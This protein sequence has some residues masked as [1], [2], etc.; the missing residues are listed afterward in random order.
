MD[1]IVLKIS[2][3]FRYFTVDQKHTADITIPSLSRMQIKK[4]EQKA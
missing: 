2:L 4:I 1:Q 3:S